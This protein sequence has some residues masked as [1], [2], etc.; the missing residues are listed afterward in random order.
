[1]KILVAVVLSLMFVVP[2]HANAC[3]GET[4]AEADLNV[5]HADPSGKVKLSNDNVEAEPSV[6]PDQ[7]RIGPFVSHDGLHLGPF[8]SHDGLHLGPFVSH[9]G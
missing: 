9:D 3:I 7:L 4:F 2:A 5:V 1:M 8:V 6:I